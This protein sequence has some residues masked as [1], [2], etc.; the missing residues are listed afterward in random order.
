MGNE[1]DQ[2]VGFGEL[3]GDGIEI[4]EGEVEG[5]QNNDQHLES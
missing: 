2:E 3:E 1:E 5:E 4:E